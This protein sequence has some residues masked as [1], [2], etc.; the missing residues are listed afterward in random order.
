MNKSA[1]SY[2][3]ASVAKTGVLDMLKMHSYR[4]NEDVFKRITIEPDGKNHGLVMF[5]DWSASMAHQHHDC[6]KQLL[7]ICL[8]THLTL[9]TSDLV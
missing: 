5:L 1:D 9:P 8:Y 4:Y 2:V 6:F 7:Q 3:R